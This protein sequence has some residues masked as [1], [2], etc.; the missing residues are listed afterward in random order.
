[1]VGESVQSRLYDGTLRRKLLVAFVGLAL[2]AGTIGAAGFVGVSQVSATTDTIVEEDAPMVDGVMMLK[3]AVEQEE[4]AVNAYMMGE[5]DSRRKLENSVSFFDRVV[6]E[7]FPEERLTAEERDRLQT[8]ES[9]HE[10]AVTHAKAAVDARGDDSTTMNAEL[11]AYRSTKEDLRGDLDE[12]EGVVKGRFDDSAASANQVELASEVA[13]VGFT[14]LAVALALLIGRRIG[15]S[16]GGEVERVRDVAESIAAGDLRVEVEASDREDEIGDLVAAFRSMTDYLRTV[17]G[18]AQA[19]ADQEFDADVL[20][21]EVP[22]TLGETL[23]Q[24]VVDIEAAQHEAQEARANVESLNEALEA[25]AADYR[26]TMERAA[27]GDLTQRMDPDSESEAMRQIATAFNDMMDDIEG[28]LVRIREFTDEVADAS[29][30]VTT[31]TQEIERASTQVSDSVQGIAA[32]TDQQTE[33]LGEV[34]AEMQQLSGSIEEIASSANE[35]ANTAREAS[36]RG[37]QGREAAGEAIEELDA[38]EA[39]A[40]ETMAE[41]DALAD[42]IEEIGEIVEFITDIAEQT[43]MLALNASIEAARAGEAG[44]GFAVVA[45]EIKGLAGEVDDATNDI[46]RLIDDI[47]NS[48]EETVDDMQELGERVAEGTTT[49]ETT[50]STLETVIDTVD[51]V[52]ASVQEINDATDD[53]AASTEGVVSMVDEV[54]EFADDA[55]AEAENASAA[56]EEQTSSVSQVTKQARSLATRTDELQELLDE[57]TVGGSVSVDAAGTGGGVAAVSDGGYDTED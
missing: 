41:V 6:R 51:D 18:Q 39:T 56:A 45:D 16:I 43:N 20:E 26:R 7:R 49:I 15:N 24:M 8:I 31:S 37:Q 23:D 30:S 17:E 22:G 21:E 13:I 57:F 4:S 46:E 19:V 38:I 32:S 54:S 5:S 44:E 1:M 3:L 55:A 33:N 34:N 10:Q 9:K 47:Q 35:V 42:E 28:T 48:T 12:F 36:D 40:D 52:N 27:E 29:Q 11:S 53:Q 14:L 25:T 50:L 2:L